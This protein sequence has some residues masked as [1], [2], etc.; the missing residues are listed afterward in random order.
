MSEQVEKRQRTITS[1]FGHLEL[2]SGPMPKEYEHE[3]VVNADY[4]EQVERELEQERGVHRY[5]QP[6]YEKSEKAEADKDQAIADRDRLAEELKKCR[7]D[8]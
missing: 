7:G 5:W 2:L 3:R 1:N 4:T 8:Q 6:Y